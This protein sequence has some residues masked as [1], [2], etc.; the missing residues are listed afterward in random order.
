MKIIV[1]HDNGTKYEMFEI[2]DSYYLDL[3]DKDHRP[4]LLA[5]ISPEIQGSTLG[6]IESF[7][8]GKLRTRVTIV[9]LL[10]E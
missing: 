2:P 3:S 9:N 5:S 7:Y 1:E 6:P 8:E 10:V 4:T